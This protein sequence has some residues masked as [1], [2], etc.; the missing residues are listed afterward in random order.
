MIKYSVYS[1]PYKIDQVY[2]SINGI[3]PLRDLATPINVSNGDAEGI[4]IELLPT[5]IISGTISLPDGDTAPAG[6]IRVSIYAGNYSTQVTIPE[7]GS[8]AGYSL[9]V[10]YNDAGSGYTVSYY[11]SPEYGYVQIGY[12][13]TEGMVL[14]SADGTIVDVS[15]GTTEGI[16]LEL[17]PGNI[18]S[19]KL[20]LPYNCTAPDGGIHVIIYAETDSGTPYDYSDD[21]IFGTI[22]TIPKGKNSIYYSLPVIGNNVGSGYIIRFDVISNGP[23]GYY[24]YYSD[25]GTS[26]NRDSAT[27]VDVSSG[28]AEGIDI[29][30]LPEFISRNVGIYISLPDGDVAPE[31]GINVVI[32]AI[33]DNGTPDDDSDDLSF[34]IS[35]EI[36]EG[37]D[38]EYCELSVPAYILNSKYVFYYETD[39][40]KDYLQKGYYSIAGTTDGYDLATPVDVNTSSGRYIALDILYGTAIVGTVSLPDGDIAPAGGIRVS[41][42]AF[43]IT[44]GLIPLYQTHTIIPEGK[45]SARY[46]LSVPTINDA[47]F[48]YR[49]CYFVGTEFGYVEQGYYSNDGTTPYINSYTP[50]YVSSGSKKEINFELLPAYVIS[51]TISLPGNDTAIPGG[52]GVVVSARHDNGTPD[53]YFDDRYYYTFVEIPYGKNSINYLLPIYIDD[54]D[55]S[56]IVGYEI[57][58]NY[59]YYTRFGYYSDSG[60]TSDRDLATP[61]DV[62]NGDVEGIDFKLIP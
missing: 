23:H 54:T 51:G 42:L 13:S 53:D 49:V 30:V 9:P 7:G 24:G 26:L 36:P 50:V 14:N 17:I 48:S 22:V 62:S 34:N 11:I 18:I 32:Y 35:V 28:G 33:N 40:G 21:Y 57:V 46:Y 29:E 2:Y 27:L 60:T 4:S 31:G 56:Y 16:N 39:S 20:S 6:G 45:N 61:V 38:G 5:N 25:T 55:V 41:I 19:G 37:W 3:T 8:S 52:I 1:E 58:R 10:S 44:E 59:D 43:N 15:S 47:N 12:Y